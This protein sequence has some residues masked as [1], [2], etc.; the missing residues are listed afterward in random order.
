[1]QTVQ[2]KHR[3][4]EVHFLNGKM[5]IQTASLPPMTVRIGDERLRQR[6]G[7]TPLRNWD[8]DGGAQPKEGAKE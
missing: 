8:D 3:S 2:L 1:M 7:G 4:A 5:F 6:E